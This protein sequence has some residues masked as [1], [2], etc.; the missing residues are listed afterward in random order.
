MK[1]MLIRNHDLGNINTRLPESVNKVQGIYPPLGLAYIAAVLK[2]E[3]DVSIVDAQALNL[4]TSELESTI[5]EEKPDVV[6]VTAMTSTLKGALEAARLAKKVDAEI[7]TVLGGPHLFIY[8]QET[9]SYDFVDFG[10]AGEGEIVFPELLEA[11]DGKRTFESIDGLAYKDNNNIKYTPATRYVKE[12]DS[13]P[14][15]ARE[16]LPNEKYFSILA[17][18]PFATMITSRGCPFR[19]A[20]CAKKKLDNVMRYRSIKNVVDEIEHALERWKFKTIWFYDDTFTLNRKRTLEFCNEVIERGLKFKWETPTRVD[21]VDLETLKLMKKAGCRRLR[22]GVE[23]GR[24]HIL[25]EMKKDI[26]L[27]DARNAIKWSRQAGIES[28]CFY[29]IGYPGESEEDIKATIDFAVELDSNWAMFSNVTPYPFTELHDRA[30]EMGLLKDADYWRKY[31]LG[32]TEE[33]I[34]YEFPEMERWVREAYKR[35]YFRPKVFYRTLASI[36]DYRQF[37]R[38]L[39]GFMAIVRFKLV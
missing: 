32:K 36:R 8:P 13:L 35:F 11:I 27:E 21:R 37:K 38:Y 6:G 7:K 33:R 30:V 28:F 17:D 23:S 10:V 25:D 4:T 26:T 9:L 18:Q 29:M 14:F 39:F 3:H 16:L 1:V 31:A 12:L 19:C 5:A 20:Y 22:Y 2:E 34:P 24:Q 15:P